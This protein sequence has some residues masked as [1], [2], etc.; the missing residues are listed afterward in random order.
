MTAQMPCKLLQKQCS[1]A[2]YIGCYP[3]MPCAFSSTVAVA[4]AG[5]HHGHII[6]EH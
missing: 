4:A 6:P 3:C 2:V 5:F 1:W